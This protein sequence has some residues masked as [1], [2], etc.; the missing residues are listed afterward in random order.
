MM[1]LAEW[2]TSRI[3]TA[4]LLRHSNTITKGNKPNFM[5]ILNNVLLLAGIIYLAGLSQS[6]VAQS[7]SSRVSKDS[8]DLS[9]GFTPL[10]CCC[11]MLESLT[12][13]ASVTTICPGTAVTFTVSN[14]TGN[15]ES[16]SPTYTWYL[17]G[18]ATSSH[19]TTYSNGALTNGAQ[20]YCQIAVVKSGCSTATLN[21]NTIIISVTPP[22]YVSGP[23]GSTSICQGGASSYVTESTSATSYT[24]SL[25][26]SSAGTISGTGTTGGVNW[27]SGFS[28]SATVNVVGNLCTETSAMASLPVTINPTVTA[29]TAPSG[30]ANVVQ[31]STSTYT[32]SGGNTTTYNW[33]LNGT[34]VSGTGASNNI[35]FPATGT[36]TVVVGVAAS[37]CNGPSSAVTKSVVISLPVSAG[38]LTPSALTIAAGT[39]PGDLTCTPATNGVGGYVYQWQSSTNGS[40]WTSVG[41]GILSYNPGTLSSSM[42]YRVMVTNSGNTAYSNTALITVGTVNTNWSYLRARDILRPGVTDTVTADGLSSPFDVAQTTEFFDGLGRTIQTVN[43]Q[44]TPL[45]NDMVS[46]EVYDNFGR[47]SVL[48]MPYVSATSDGNF[49]STAASDQ[50]AFNAS[51]FPNEQYYYS[52]IIYEASPLNRPI[53]NNAPGVNW[54]GG[55]RGLSQQYLIN[56]SSDS[57]QIWSISSQQLSLPVDNGVYLAG[58]L[59]KSMSV[60][61]NGNQKIDYLDKLGRTILSKSQTSASPS[62]GHSGWSCTYYVYDT[63]QNL[64]VI[65]QPKAIALINGTWSISASIANE[66]CF[67]YEYDG[68]KR[69]IIKKLPGAGQIW[70]VYDARD[71][72]VLQ[73]DSVLRS[74]QKWRY[75]KYDAEDRPDSTGT[76]NNASSQAY[77]DSLAYYSTSYPIVANYTNELLAQNFYDDYSWVST[78]GAPVSA[79]MAT[80][81]TSN[82]NYFI[83][84]VNTSPNYAVS[85]TMFPITRGRETGAMKKVIGSASQ[86]LYSINFFDDRGRTI[87]TQSVNYTGAIDTTTI[88]YNFR[89][90]VL[91]TL[92]NHNKGGNT[93]QNHIVLTKFDYDARYRLKHIWKNIDGAQSDQLID[94]MQYNELGQLRAKYLGNNI[95]SLIYDYNI[96][97]WLTGINKNYVA[98]S[99]NQYFGMELGFD[100]SASVAPGNTYLVQEYNGN[101]AGTVWKSAGSGINRK[102]DYSYDNAS[103]LVSAA[104]LQNTSG[105]SWDKNQVD[106]SVGNLTYDANGNILTM[107]QKGFMVGGSSFIDQL[108]YSYSANGNRLIQVYDTANN[109][110]S[111]L[112]DFHWNGTKQDSD[113]LYD[114]NG[115]VLQDNN[116]AV[117]G[118]TYNYLNLPQ[119][120][121]MNGKGNITYTYDAAGTKL[122]KVITDSTAGRSTTILYIGGFVYQQTDTIINPGGG[123]DTLQFI[124][125][126]EGRARWAFHK[127][128]SGST[129]YKLEY[130]FFEKDHLGNTRMVL[131]QQRDTANYLASME[132]AYRST[133]SQLFANIAST[134]VAWTSVPNYQNIPSGTLLGITSPNDSVSKVDYTGTSGQKTGPSL[135][136]KVMSGDTISMAVQAFYNSNSITTTN[137]SFN[138]VLNS[139]AAGL[140]GTATG[141]AEG[142]SLSGFTASSSPVYS[143]VNSFLPTNDPAPPSGYP[144]AYLNW[145]LLDDQFNYVSSSSGSVAAASGTYPAGQLNTVAPGGPLTIPRNGYLYVWVSNET[146]GWDVFFDNLSVQYKQGPLLEENHYYPFGLAMA[147]ISDKAVKTQYTE[148]KY[149][150]NSGSEL[151]NKEFSDGTGLELYETSSRSYDPQLGRFFQIDPLA[152]EF[153]TF[154][155]YQFAEDNPA[156]FTDPT[157]AYKQTN[158][159]YS[160][161]S[162][163]VDQAMA[164][165]AATMA[166]ED[167][168]NGG[169]E[170]NDPLFSMLTSLLSQAGDGFTKYLVNPDGTLKQVAY[171]PDPTVGTFKGS[172]GIWVNSVTSLDDGSDGLYYTYGDY[173]FG[174]SRS[175]DVYTHEFVS[176]S[177]AV[178]SYT[179]YNTPDWWDYT[180]QAASIGVGVLEIGASF[181]SGGLLA[182]IL[183]V[184]GGARIVNGLGR[185]YTLTTQGKV[186]AQ[187][188]PTNLLGD[189]GA[190]IEGTGSKTQFYMQ[191]GNDILTM[192]FFPGEE[193][194][195]IGSDGLFGDAGTVIKSIG[196]GSFGKA[197]TAGTEVVDD[198]GSLTEQQEKLSEP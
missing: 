59:F 198:I 21:S 18:S 80:N 150:Y 14:F 60:D 73:Q 161:L 112:G 109:P 79:T 128:T 138:D 107:E 190:V 188:L 177:T 136:L 48:Y 88:Q 67:R 91:R 27:S 124:V 185:L 34:A 178:S 111:L 142:G 78:Y 92:V 168:D 5:K 82:A 66:L 33:T 23:S 86:Y 131:T 170:N 145:I 29:P 32:T 117:S 171:D 3:K 39:G 129:A 180:K 106:F 56:T 104:F 55:G 140:V 101:V 169:S 8:A 76:I 10:L 89:G 113:Y 118:I 41:T 125:H 87:Q 184:D 12:I 24:W 126:E 167:A 84:S 85:M 116:K 175:T 30:S 146:Q 158:I 162:S 149:R 195:E 68:R 159:T 182:P 196:S 163:G 99:T 35:T 36:G 193:A 153:S 181:A 70:S 65:I 187:N 37:G 28:G 102:Y 179:T 22:P 135:L 123:N 133:E 7:D 174:G 93:V 51:Q 114:G 4:T 95:D 58:Q 120:I 154:S 141:H 103:R 13:T 148:N 176:A 192:V 94:S 151:Q 191:S 97:G 122:S 160:K 197:A 62:T 19:G 72:L 54:V 45:Q 172:T 98:G 110:T 90:A 52:Q 61:E 31:G 11:P 156:L 16:G 166:A 15:L 186:A 165:A 130:D 119:L 147:G 2:H 115:N 134:S 183:G 144:K 6:A 189:I 63:L 43:M 20:V 9:K 64:R 53:G 127:Y 77:H 71:R 173:D 46:P 105:S 143:A 83:T 42:Y 47:K 38:E 152:G 96:R 157:G 194:G 69:M 25:T 139:L 121:H 75:V 49:K 164:M 137:S 26:P 50:Y 1:V 17:N 74:Q 40:T 155:T 100:K 81:Y 44:A 108:K 57:V 132:A